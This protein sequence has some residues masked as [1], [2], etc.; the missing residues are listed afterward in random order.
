MPD[1]NV[2]K[3][4]RTIEQVVREPLRFK[5]KLDI[6]EDAYQSLKIKKFALDAMDAGNGM[7]LGVGIAKSSVVASTFFAP[8]GFLGA[9]GLGTAVTPVGWAIAAGVVGASLS[10]V[11]GKKIIR[12]TSSRVIVIPEFINTPL[13]LLA[14]TLFDLIACLGLK[15]AAVD[16]SITADE[17]RFIEDY[18]VQEWGFDRVF[19][20]AGLDT[21]EKEL[22]SYKIKE[23]TEKLALFKKSNPD[24]NY[25][26]LSKE[27]II[28]V[29]GISESDGI[30]D[31]REALAINDVQKVFDEVSRFSVKNKLNNVANVATNTSQKGINLVKTSI[32][33]TATKISD[34]HTKTT[35]SIKKF[36]LRKNQ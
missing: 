24:C 17:R 9:I 27:L 30:V 25:E 36:I 11:I 33:S 20:T 29:T 10:V 35:D 18:F 21:I 19:V 26:S 34:T 4:D 5:A 14:S 32:Q 12:G 15:I 23:I 6:G 31:D 13:D 8:S 16:G 28:F 3:W 7:V 2:D 22:D 1:L